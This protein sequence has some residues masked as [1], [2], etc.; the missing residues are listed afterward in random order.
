MARRRAEPTVA[1]FRVKSGRAV[2]V[3]VG[4]SRAAPRVLARS[5]VELCDPGMPTSRQPYHR[6]FG[7][8]EKNEMRLA[9]RIAAVRRATAASVGALLAEWKAAGL[10]VQA[11]VL[12]AGSLQAP[13]AI[14]NEHIR[15]HALEGQLFRTVLA[16][17][18]ASA[19]VRSLVVAERNV[20]GEA[21]RALSLDEPALRAAL[22][23]LGRVVG[24]PWQA[25]HKL[26]AAA[27]WTQ[28]D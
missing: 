5:E 24:R 17:A 18:L 28:L 9:S 26:A 1:G 6:G 14:G 19:G 25:D 2:T 23:E 22:G 3:L 12:V 27:A 10:E 11:A 15:A 8:L 4:G 21:S 7:S 13:E 20:L 16:E